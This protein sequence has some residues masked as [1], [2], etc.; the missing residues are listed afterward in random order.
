MMDPTQSG[1]P[2]FAVEK[3]MNQFLRTII[4]TALIVATV[5]SRQSAAQTSTDD[6]GD[7]RNDRRLMAIN[8]GIISGP[9]GDGGQIVPGWAP[10]AEAEAFLKRGDLARAEAA[11][12]K[13][14]TLAPKGLDVT[15]FGGHIFEILGEIRLRQGKYVAARDFFLATGPH[16]GSEMRDLGLV[17]AYCRLNDYADALNG[18]HWI[19][20]IDAHDEFLDEKDPDRPGYRNVRE[21][22]AS[23]L[24]AKAQRFH[25]FLCNYG[26]AELT[27]AEKLLPDN[28]MVAYELAKVLRENKK[29]AEAITRF[30]R[31]ARYG[32]GD[33]A[34]QAKSHAET[35]GAWVKL[36]AE[37]VKLAPSTVSSTTGK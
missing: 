36:Q 20:T 27:A 15:R 19:G 31:A 10:G 7:A 21:I 22:E 25:G 17:L 30:N 23:V 5:C 14:F 16:Y 3:I 32:H 24:L 18:Y 4:W 37:K 28:A 8:Q 29:Y 13:V 12:Q 9:S 1:R 34:K 2:R 11:I 6:G 33:L 35:V 26:E